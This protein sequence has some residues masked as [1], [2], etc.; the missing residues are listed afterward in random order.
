[1]NSKLVFF[2]RSNND[3]D[4]MCPII[5]RISEIN[6][7]SHI[8]IYT[9][10]VD[11]YFPTDFRIKFLQKISNVSYCGDVVINSS[12]NFL[13]KALVQSII[14][15]NARKISS[16]FSDKLMVFLTKIYQKKINNISFS[17]RFIRENLTDISAIVFDHSYYDFYSNIAAQNLKYGYK[18]IA[19]PHGHDLFLN[20][21]IKD[22]LFYKNPSNLQ[23]PTIESK[24]DKIIFHNEFYMNS[25]ID[26]GIVSKE[27]SLSLGSSR[28]DLRWVKKLREMRKS[29]RQVDLF[30]DKKIKIVFMLSKQ[31]YNSFPEELDRI[32]KLLSLFDEIGVVIKP[33]TR[34]QKFLS[35]KYNNIFFDN[36]HE[37]YSTDLIDWCDVVLFEHSCICLD[38]IQLNKPT[39][40]ISS[41]HAN[42]LVSNG[43]MLNW[44]VRTRDDLASFINRFISDPSTKTYTSKEKNKF[45]SQTIHEKSTTPL[46]DYA[47]LVL[48]I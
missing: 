19:T 27:N 40:L 4:H 15:L 33:H 35:K 42:L 1:M 11:H 26:R 28:F 45:L 8:S 3:L 32:V 6:K 23:M 7:E 24:V 44:E 34:N 25:A 41:T 36:K 2:I 21:M 39:I 29:L 12:N 16:R 14:F 22:H 20:R 13:D 48:N 17:N 30:D 10:G 18:T 31:G 47:E 9:T 5:W 38:P 46:D 37:F 43:V